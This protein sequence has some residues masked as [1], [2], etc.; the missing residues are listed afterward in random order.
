MPVV[1]AKL[2]GLRATLESDVAQ[3]RT[4]L[5]RFSERTGCGSTPMGGSRA[6]PGWTRK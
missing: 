2:A 3:G 5:G 6:R 1:R 4:A